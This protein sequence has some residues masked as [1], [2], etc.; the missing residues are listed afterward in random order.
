MEQVKVKSIRRETSDSVVISFNIAEEITQLFDHK[1]GQYVT[2]VAEIGGEE[3]RRAYSICS[4]PHESYIQVGVK[5]V[6]GGKMSTYLVDSLVEG[7]QLSLITPEGRFVLKADHEKSRDHYFIAAGSGITPILSMIKSVLEEEP[8]SFCYLLYGNRTEQ[9]IM[10]KEELD[11][12]AHRYKGQLIVEHTLSQPKEEKKKGLSGLF[13]AKSSSWSGMTGRISATSITQFI[14]LYPGEELTKEYYICGPGNM[15]EEVTAHLK[16]MNIDNKSIHKEY[17][18]SPDDKNSKTVAAPG[19]KGKKSITV[20]LNNEEMTFEIASDKTIVDALV[21]MGKDVPY[22][23]SSGACATCIAKLT[24][25]EVK[26][27]S[28]FALDDE[29]IAQGY[30]LTCQ[31]CLVSDTA[32]VEFDS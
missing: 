18:S 1:A 3:I 9:D 31:A 20:H 24:Q 2:I 25:G 26:M 10:F 12:L 6:A 30:I 7:Q 13:G 23:C 21:E 22:S 17:F 5:K 29:E 8:K 19:P 14:D 16:S 28:C 4:A 27:E 15:I 11:T 32:V